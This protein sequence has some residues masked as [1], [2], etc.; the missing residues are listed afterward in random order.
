MICTGRHPH[1]SSANQL[2]TSKESFAAWGINPS[3]HP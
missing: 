1:H 2:L 3:I